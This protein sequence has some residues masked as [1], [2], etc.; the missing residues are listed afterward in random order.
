MWL[1]HLRL[2]WPCPHPPARPPNRSL[3]ARAARAAPAHRAR[4][5]AP[6]AAAAAAA[7]AA[8]VPTVADTKAAFTRAYPRP[9]PSV[10]ST[11]VQ[12]LLVQ[13]HL[14]KCNVDYRYSAVAA[15]GLVSTFDQLLD[16]MAAADREAIFT[17]WVSALGDDPARWR[18]DAAALE[19]WARGA[20][21]PAAVA[22]G[23]VGAGP[24][25][26][27]AAADA[28]KSGEFLYTKFF[29]VGLF[30]LLELAGG[31]DPKALAALVEALGAPAERVSADLLTYKGV[32]S[33][34]ASAKAMMAE[35]LEREKKKTA[36]RLAEKEAK[37]AARAAKAAEP[38]AAPAAA[39]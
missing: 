11:V 36:E 30:R 39:E 4:A 3:P 7:A 13:M 31:K 32:L 18:A 34:M 10:Y 29:A 26:L 20:G 23:G 14:Y 25:A 21:A 1:P 15:L 19:E 8:A 37:A 38:A 2:S 16:G 5:P 12:E 17:A 27:A 22:P 28:F 24:Q 6:R 9:L 33:K 35:F